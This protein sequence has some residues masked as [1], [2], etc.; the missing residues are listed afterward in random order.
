M[1]VLSVVLLSVGLMLCAAG[2]VLAQDG[3]SQALLGGQT[4]VFNDTP[5]AFG[6]PAP[7][8]SREERLLFAVG[9][10]FFRLN[11]VTA[12]ASTEA[13]DGLGPLFNSRSCAGCHFK[14]G[15]G[16]PPE[17]D[18]E[19]PTGYL[20]RLKIPERT[21]SGAYLG[22]PNYGGQFQTEALERIAAEGDLRIT[23]VELPGQ[24]ADGTPYSLRQPVVTLEN[25]NYGE[26]DPEVT[27]SP[28]VASQMIGLGLLEA[29]PQEMLL[30]LADPTDADG[31]GI[32]GRPNWVWDLYNNRR[33]MGRFGW[34]A[35]QPH[36]L[37]QVASAFSGDMG[38]TTGLL[39]LQ[40]CT[41]VQ[42]DCAAA[43]EGGTPEISDDDLL[44]VVL[45]TQTLAVPAQRNVDDPLVQRGRELFAEAKCSACHVETLA[46]GI[47]PEAPTL[48]HQIIHPYTD[49]LLHDMGEG[50][51]DGSPDFEATGSE[52]RTPPLW[53]I[54]LIETVNGHTNFL[55]DG[56]A[57][58]LAE[59][60][61]WHGG[62]GAASA[63]AFRTMSAD[64]RAALL[65][66]LKSF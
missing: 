39:P 46:T 26:L 3:Q 35:N 64:D 36:L 12:P 38:I 27:L 45:Y 66:L 23:Y 59:A 44:K 48:S 49:L 13:R 47:H 43:V 40:N 11:W 51:A 9:N 58:N 41:A 50:L 16:R 31:D 54:G 42:A 53:G 8:L 28:R 55:H 30:A 17:F 5:N 19:A 4:T 21:L 24:Y 18:G 25:L 7:G 29:V 65:A 33:A 20:V 56:R 61:L 22:D 62:E 63:E 32:S 60:I 10:S 2:L 52:W 37:Q 14:D 57:R 34:K 1:R 6:F 15:R